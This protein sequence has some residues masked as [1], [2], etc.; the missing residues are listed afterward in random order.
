[1]QFLRVGG[2][3]TPGEG[4]EMDTRKRTVLKAVLWNLLGLVTMG[5]VGLVM[6]GSA[7]LGGAM[8]VANTAVGLVAYIAYER[9]WAQVRWGREERAHG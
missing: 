4:A 7:R 1:M 2:H 5:L 6:T 9:L 3:S 8:A